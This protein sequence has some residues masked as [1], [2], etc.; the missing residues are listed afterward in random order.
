MYA[1]LE[2]AGLIKT[3]QHS[4]N[5]TKI[6]RYFLKNGK[7]CLQNQRNKNLQETLYLMAKC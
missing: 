6:I 3:E 7:G 4:A 2:T 5:V 1:Q